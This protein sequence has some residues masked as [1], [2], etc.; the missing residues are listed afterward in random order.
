[1]PLLRAGTDQYAVRAS[2]DAIFRMMKIGYSLSQSRQPH[3]RQVGFLSGIVLER[4]NDHERYRERRLPQAQPVYTPALEP[5]TVGLLVY[6]ERYG[7]L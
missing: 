2:M 1:M 4:V 3:D 6:G 5:E 7:L